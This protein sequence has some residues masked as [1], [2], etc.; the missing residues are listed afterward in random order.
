MWKYDGD[1]LMY[2]EDLD[3]EPYQF[4]VGSPEREKT[5]KE[6][7]FHG[8]K[9]CHVNIQFVFT[10]SDRRRRRASRLKFLFSRQNSRCR[11]SP[12]AIDRRRRRDFHRCS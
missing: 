7:I 2:R 3:I 4:R 9:R 11:S 12:S 1:L 6:M 5:K 8:F 10:S